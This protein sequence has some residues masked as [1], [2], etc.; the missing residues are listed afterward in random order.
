MP[1]F[2]SEW[3]RPALKAYGT[4]EKAL[5]GINDCEALIQGTVA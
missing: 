3:N 4:E 1:P 5:I 2:L